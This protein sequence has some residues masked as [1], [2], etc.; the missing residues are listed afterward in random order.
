MTRLTKFI[1]RGMGVKGKTRRPRCG[2]SHT[3]LHRRSSS[4]L[5]FAY[6]CKYAFRNCLRGRCGGRRGV[7]RE[8][9]R[10]PAR[11]IWIPRPAQRK[12]PHSRHCLEF[13]AFS[14][15]R[16]RRRIYDDE[17]C[18]RRLRR[19]N[20]ADPMTKSRHR[21]GRKLKHTRNQRLA[22]R[23]G[24]VG[25]SEGSPPIQFRPRAHR[26]SHSGRR[27]KHPGIFFAGNF[28][29][30]PAI[31]KCVEQAFTTADAVQNFF[32]SGDRA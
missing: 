4:G 18:G 32:K 25:T 21:A 14:R 13:L 22:G 9:D 27:T 3:S 15:A 23:F 8:S 19:R 20:H 2:R 16:P 6:P 12:T 26:R 29:E 1:S 31:G 5:A 17:F 11:W 7:L 10:T 24:P 30:G 28:L